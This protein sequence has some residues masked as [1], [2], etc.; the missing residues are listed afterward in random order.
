MG[1]CGG[2]IIPF[3]PGRADATGPVGQGFVPLPEQSTESHLQAF[4]RM[5]FSQTEMI[6]LIAAGHT[7]GQVHA[8]VNPRIVATGIQAFDDTRTTYDN[9]VALDYVRDIRTNP[10]GQVYDPAFPERSSDTRAFGSD[11]NAT[12]GQLAASSENFM[13]ATGAVLLKMFNEGG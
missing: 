9:H 2:P 3:H 11:G 7:I 4:A 13:S 6:Q 12:I 10:L 1:S 5:G 8:N